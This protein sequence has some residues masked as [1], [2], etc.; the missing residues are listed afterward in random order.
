[1][2][3]SPSSDLRESAGFVGG[4]FKQI[5]LAWRLYKDARVSGWVK[6]IPMAGLLYLLSPVDL[7]PDLM[8]PG[9][10]Q[11]DDMVMLLLALKM[12]VDLS[13]PSIVREHVQDLF[14]ATKAT[15]R[16]EQQ[17]I[18]VPYRVIDDEK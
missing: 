6:L 10:G 13:P 9:L 5:R 15:P 4:L 14:G 1:M 8:L 18:D 11:V 17:Y 12:F 16:N 2:R 7:L 3:K